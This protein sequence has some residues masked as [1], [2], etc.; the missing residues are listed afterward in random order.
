MYLFRR[1][2]K[3]QPEPN[4]ATLI[5]AS[6]IAVKT[7]HRLSTAEWL[8]LTPQEQAEHRASVVAA[9]GNGRAA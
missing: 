3:P 5:P 1:P 7:A 8:S 6:D 2:P 9:L 4:P